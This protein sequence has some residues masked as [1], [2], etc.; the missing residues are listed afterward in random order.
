MDQKLG[1]SPESRPR[2]LLAD[3]HAGILAALRRLL[4]PSCEIVGSVMD[5]VALIEAASRLEPDVIVADVAMPELDGIAAGQ[6]IKQAMPQVKI[7]F[8]TASSDTDVK[9]KALSVGASAFV[10]KRAMADKLPKAIQE[11][12]SEE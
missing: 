8:L 2:V 5:G 11:A 4:S 1:V 7:I 3:D 12:L 10:E 6:R 9:E